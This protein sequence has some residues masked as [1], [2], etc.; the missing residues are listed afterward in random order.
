MESL[1]TQVTFSEFFNVAKSLGSLL[2]LG[3]CAWLALRW[4][5]SRVEVLSEK[6]RLEPLV[7]EFAITTA[8]VILY[9][10]VIVSALSSLGIQTHSLVA[11]IGAAGLAVGLALQNSLSNLAAGILLAGNKVFKKLDYVEINGVAG[12]VESVGLLTTTLRTVDNK[13]VTIPNNSCLSNNI[14]NFSNFPTR[15]ID[16]RVS[17]AYEDEV[18][19]AKRLLIELFDSSPLVI[20]KVD[21]M[22]GVE[23]FGEYGVNLLARVWVTT[24]N[25]LVAQMEL[26]EQ[27][28]AVFDDS[29]ITIP[30]PRVDISGFA[31]YSLALARGQSEAARA[32]ESIIAP[33]QS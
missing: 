11:A 6:L 17:I 14:I 29:K 20:D 30:Y 28:K 16:L 31:E 27:I 19:E 12:K 18:A 21:V 4:M 5:A 7:T 26:L 23:S 1:V 32:P 9:I 22:V 15:R 33:K 3:L 10:V 13:T 2:I 25:V 24:D 8:K